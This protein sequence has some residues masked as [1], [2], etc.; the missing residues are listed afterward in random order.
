MQFVRC[1]QAHLQ[2]LQKKEEDSPADVLIKYLVPPPVQ[3]EFVEVFKGVKDGKY[4]Q[5]ILQLQSV[6]MS[7]DSGA[8]TNFSSFVSR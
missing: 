4:E 6:R 3:E 5:P 8:A 2:S 1:W 7:S